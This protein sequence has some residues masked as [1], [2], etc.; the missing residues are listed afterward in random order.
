MANV[1]EVARMGYKA[2]LTHNPQDFFDGT[3][4]FELCEMVRFE[5]GNSRSEIQRILNMVA[6]GYKA[7]LVFDDGGG[8]GRKDNLD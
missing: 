7:V 8:H 6:N 5:N 3:E 4:P 1:A 2:I